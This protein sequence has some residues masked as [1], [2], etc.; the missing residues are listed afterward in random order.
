M[1]EVQLNTQSMQKPT[2]TFHANAVEFF[3]A[4]ANGGGKSFHVG[5]IKSIELAVDNKG[6]QKLVLKTD[7]HTVTEDVDEKAVSKAQ[8]LVAAV[9]AAM[10]I[11]SI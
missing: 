10:K 6:K 11:V 5:H 9:Q 7:F 1:F 2:V 3:Y 8:K 4:T